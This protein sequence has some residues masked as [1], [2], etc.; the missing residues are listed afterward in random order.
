MSTFQAARQPAQQVTWPEP[1][2]V[3]RGLPRGFW[4]SSRFLHD[5]LP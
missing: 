2:D 5:F 1:G 3:S 4:K